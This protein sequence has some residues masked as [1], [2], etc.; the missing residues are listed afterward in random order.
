VLGPRRYDPSTARFST[1][2]SYVAG[3]LDLG[4]ALD[5]LTGNRYLFAGANPVA[6]FDDGHAPREEL[7]R[8]GRPYPRP[9]PPEERLHRVSREDLERNARTGTGPA[10]V[11]GEALPRQTDAPSGREATAAAEGTT[12]SP[13]TPLAATA[14]GMPSTPTTTTTRSST[15]STRLPRAASFDGSSRWITPRCTPTCSDALASVS[16][17]LPLVMS[18]H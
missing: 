2:D 9:P 18:F 6:Y 10:S 17:G 4:L 7:Y 11:A 16:K 15:L 14:R 1:A 13:T 3:G 5:P 8:E 12:S